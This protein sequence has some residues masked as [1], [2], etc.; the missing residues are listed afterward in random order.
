MAD[1]RVEGGASGSR[2]RVSI[3][4]WRPRIPIRLNPTETRFSEAGL[5]PKPL[6]QH[7]PEKNEL[8]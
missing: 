3:H 2:G 7:L 1:A 5:A 4:S 8:T 6:F